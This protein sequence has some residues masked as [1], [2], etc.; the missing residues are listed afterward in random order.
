MQLLPI[1]PPTSIL[2]SETDPHICKT[3]KNS[4]LADWRLYICGLTKKPYEEAIKLVRPTTLAWTT[5]QCLLGGRKLPPTRIPLTCATK[6]AEIRQSRWLIDCPFCSNISMLA[7]KISPYFWCPKCYMQQGFGEVIK[8]VF[9]ANAKEI[10]TVLMRRFDFYNRNW[11]L[12]ESVEDLRR[13]N[14]AHGI[15][16]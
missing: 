15:G 4:Q 13:E 16:V 6:Q 11:L 5:Y 8:V 7:S 12:S 9:P 10:E 14:I 2:V 3:L 1:E